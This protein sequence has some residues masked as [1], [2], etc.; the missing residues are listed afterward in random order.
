MAASGCATI[1]S[2]EDPQEK[3]EIAQTYA[4]QTRQA[5]D[6]VNTIVAQTM[7]AMPTVTDEPTPEDQTPSPA[8][9]EP[10]LTHTPTDQPTETP[11]LTLTHTA[12]ATSSVPLI[13]V[14]VPT[15]C[16]VGPGRAY[17]IVSVLRTGKT[18]IIL[19]RHPSLDFWVIENP[20]GAG[21]C[22]VW[23][24]YATLSGPIANLPVWTPPPTP[25]PTATPV[26]GVSPTPTEVTLRVS[27]PTNCRVGPGKPYDIIS[28]LHTGKTANVLA[29]HASADFWVIENP[30][31]LGHC[32]VWGEHATLSGPVSKLPIWDPPPTPTP[33][34]TTGPTPTPTGVTLQVSVATNCRVGPGQAYGIISILRT[35]KVAKVLARHASA[36]FWVIENPEGPGHCWVWGEYATLNGPVSKLPVWDPPPT[37][38][39]AVT[40]TPTMT[41]SPTPT[42]MPT[43][44]ATP[45][46]TPTQT[47][48][49]TPTPNSPSTSQVLAWGNGDLTQLTARVYEEDPDVDIDRY[50]YAI[51]ITPGGSDVVKWTETIQTQITHNGLQ[52]QSGKAY[53]VS[54]QSRSANGVWR[55]AGVSNPVVDGSPL[56][57]PVLMNLEPMS[58]TAG[59]GGFTLTVMGEFFLEEAVVRWNG[60][61]RPT[62]FVN[63][64]KL[65]VQ[66]SAADI[67]SIGEG[68]IT[69]FIP[70]PGGGMSNGL[71]FTITTA[72]IVTPDPAGI[73]MPTLIK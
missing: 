10:T 3:F 61:E 52:L 43:E 72:P 44:T 25:T 57:A 41:P 28:V 29:R 15:N 62:T 36:D 27:V 47:P 46:E 31:G 5:Q 50:S 7:T 4:V 9:V 53:Y 8:P 6:L 63:P 30:K 49:P 60:G 66:I 33:K 64:K 12:S 68:I 23:G 73:P 11:T 26:S 34:A 37:P 35:N 58:I 2:R 39:P 65:E 45:T 38:T 17:D 56:P 42:P 13:E 71:T 32:W 1:F 51:G 48:T 54:F 55:D 67:S 21:H 16:R 59:G 69:V 14:S 24:E 19:A 20:G 40:H 18:A 22:W 70:S